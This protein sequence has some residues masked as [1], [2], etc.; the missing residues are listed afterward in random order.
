MVGVPSCGVSPPTTSTSPNSTISPGLPFTRSTRITSSAATR[1][2]LPPVLMTANIFFV[3]VFDPGA[4][5]VPDRLLSV[6]LLFVFKGLVSALE[7][8]RGPEGPRAMLMAGKSPVCQET[9]HFLV[10]PR[11]GGGFRFLFLPGPNPAK[12]GHR[13]HYP[14][15]PTGSRHPV[16]SPEFSASRGAARS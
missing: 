15:A 9:R 11:Q 6:G 3:L 5:T 16:R 4:R 1:Y 13:S 10:A 2:C 8:S 7:K 14:I 12:P